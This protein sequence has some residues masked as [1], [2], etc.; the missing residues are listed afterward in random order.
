[1]K[2]PKSWEEVPLKHYI[3]I[4]EISFVDMDEIDKA[5]KILS[6]LSGEPEENIIELSV[7]EIANYTKQVAFVYVEH[8]GKGVP[9]SVKLKGKRYHINNGIRLLSG[10]EYIDF[11]SLVKDKKDIAI[12]LPQI[13]AIFMKPINWYGGNKKGCYRK[14][15][16]G[17]YVQTLQSRINTARDCQDL[18]SNIAMELAG[19]FLKS[20]ESSM[21]ATQ[22][23]LR[24]EQ[25]KTM[26]KLQKELR[27]FENTGLGIL[28]LIIFLIT[29]EQSGISFLI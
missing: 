8:K 11:T 19:F 10:A 16:E 14:N 24:L 13:L 25:L 2:L 1:M 9:T 20:Y 6:I 23:Y 12:N 22:N 29:I 3:E 28:P 5:V 7:Q 26:K 27:G 17:N 4:S 15:P 21:R 18:P